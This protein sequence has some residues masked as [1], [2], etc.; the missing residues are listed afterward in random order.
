M[1]S[2]LGWLSS[3]TRRLQIWSRASSPGELENKTPG[4]ILNNNVDTGNLG[5]RENV[6]RKKVWGGRRRGLWTLFS[7]GEN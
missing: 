5:K 7:R 6:P 3:D 1:Q 4:V 2:L